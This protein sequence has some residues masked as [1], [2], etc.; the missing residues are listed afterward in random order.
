MRS[1]RLNVVACGCMWVACGLHVV[2]SGGGSA[3]WR[4]RWGGKEGNP[5]SSE[6][7]FM[8]LRLSAGAGGLRTLRETA[9]P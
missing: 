8:C 2:A 1:G 5:P 6:S 7:W 4:R 9:A 3:V